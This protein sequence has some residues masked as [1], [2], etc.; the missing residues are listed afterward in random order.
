MAH[1]VLAYMLVT[2]SPSPGA[3]HNIFRF[4]RGFR[5]NGDH[6]KIREV[7]KFS[8]SFL[9]Y[10]WDVPVTIETPSIKRDVVLFNGSTGINYRLSTCRS[11]FD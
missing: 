7:F 11:L 10:K 9:S 8:L 2:P 4:Q 5:I 6:I 1:P 3:G